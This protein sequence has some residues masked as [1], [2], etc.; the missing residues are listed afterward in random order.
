MGRAKK[1]NKPKAA[2]FLPS[3]KFS[4]V[5]ASSFSSEMGAKAR[6]V[7]SSATIRV[8]PAAFES[9]VVVSS[10]LEGS[11]SSPVG[12]CFKAHLMSLLKDSPGPSLGSMGKETPAPSLDIPDKESPALISPE[13]SKEAGSR[14]EDDSTG[15]RADEGSNLKKE[16]SSAALKTPPAPEQ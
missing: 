15:V 4:R 12:S 13:D 11:L 9:L 1:K 8:P 6:Q 10:D 14:N 3:S 5:L 16:E 2:A 7:S